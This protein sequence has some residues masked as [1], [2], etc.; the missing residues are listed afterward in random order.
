MGPL[1]KRE[2]GEAERLDW[3]RLIRSENVGPITFYRLLELCGT[4]GAALERL[5]DLARKG[6]RKRTLKIAGRSEV[7]REYERLLALGGWCLALVEPQYPYLLAQTDGAPPV[8]SGL[9]HRH[10]LERNKTVAIVGARN[11][12]AAGRGFAAKLA[13]ELG[14]ANYLLVSGMARGIDTAAHDGALKSGTLAV[15]GGGI[16]IIYPR[17]NEKLYRQLCESGALVAEAPLG[18]EPQA[19]HF[20]RR[21]R[22]I[23]G[24]SL[25]VI[26]VEAAIRSGS[27]ITARLAL[28]QGREV[29]AVPGSPLDPRARGCNRLIRDGA[30]LIENAGDVLAALEEGIRPLTAE[31]EQRSFAGFDGQSAPE[32]LLDRLRPK[33]EELLGPV[34]VAV[35]EILRQCDISPAVLQVLLLELELAGRLTRHAGHRVSLSEQPLL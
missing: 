17:E 23:S 34:P 22:I 4:A 32:D 19:R 13:R 9:G 27:L 11:A 20:P 8:I 14:D 6:G 24:L 12:S 3:L 29:F 35:D 7:E 28:E 2:L 16:N 5:P 18:T 1:E 26:V 33:V 21:N 25:G 31:P 15:L 30:A 10:L